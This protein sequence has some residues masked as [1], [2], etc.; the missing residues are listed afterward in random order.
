M[1]KGFSRIFNGT[2]ATIAFRLNEK[3]PK[4]KKDYNNAESIDVDIVNKVN[5]ITEHGVPIKGIPNSA[6][7]KYNKRGT[8]ITE[9][10]YDSNGN[11][12][13]DIDYTNHGNSGNHSI[14]PHQ[15]R[16]TIIGNKI[17]RE[18]GVGIRK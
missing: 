5:K 7:Q 1:S 8:L 9:R 10:Y 6:N 3:V 16:I 11:A 14:V 2:R 4:N 18:K 13:L 17:I 15:H 12:Y